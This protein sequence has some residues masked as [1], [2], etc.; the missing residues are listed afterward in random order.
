M[1]G[2]CV[3]GLAIWGYLWFSFVAVVAA[4]QGDIVPTDKPLGTDGPLSTDGPLG[5]DHP[6]RPNILWITSEDNGIELGCYGDTYATTPHIDRLAAQGF[7]YLNAWSNAP[8]CAPART[9]II[10]GMF[11]SSTGSEHMRSLVKLPAGFRMFP[12]YLRDAGYYCSN[13]SKQDYNLEMPGT[14]WDESSRQAHWKNH[15]PDQPFFAVFNITTSHE[16][17]IRK[18]PHQLVHDPAQAPLPSYHP[19]TPE[20]RHD[21]AQ[22]YDKLTEMDAEV[23]ARLRELQAAGLS[24]QTIIFY[25]GD[26]G[27]GMPRSKRWLYQSGLQVPLVVY[28]PEKFRHLAPASYRPGGRSQRLV[29]FIDLAPTVLSL[30]GIESPQN[31]QGSPF[32][33]EISSSEPQFQFGYRARMDSRPDLS[34]A[35]RDQH[36]LYIRNYL[37]HRPQG[38]YLAYMFQTPTT[39]VWK[40]RFDLG[41]LQ[42]PQ[43]YFWQCKQPEELYDLAS[44]PEQIHNLVNQPEQQAKLKRMR[45]VLHDHLLNIRDISFLPEAEMQA[46]CVDRTPYDLAQDK[47]A[48][49][50]RRILQT[51]ELASAV[52]SDTPIDGSSY[53]ELERALTDADSGVRYWAAMGLLIRGKPAIRVAH[54]QLHAMLHDPSPSVKTVVADALAQFGGSDDLESA[55]SVLVDLADVSRHGIWVAMGALNVLDELDEKALSVVDQLRDLPETDPAAPARYQTYPTRIRQSLFDDLESH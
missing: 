51:A 14:V 30:A 45:K 41:Q 35:V 50:L 16:S 13:N 29:G 40:R 33:G 2:I 38:Q 3:V 15:Q 5:T 4:G 42:P 54:D 47:R 43:T 26:H 36:S 53:A 44:D 20:V 55:L 6:Q 27:S 21:W 19:D 39:Q 28:I 23:G 11:P 22:Y 46:R 17:R 9:T 18:R 32:L 34:R 10:S 7:L 52:T 24:E 1:Y 25:Y 31:Y 37:P 8:V 49:P 12:Q 48:Y